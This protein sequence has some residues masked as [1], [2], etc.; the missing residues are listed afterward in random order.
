MLRFRGPCT[1]TDRVIACRESELLWPHLTPGSCPLTWKQ[2]RWKQRLRASMTMAAPLPRK[3]SHTQQVL[4]PPTILGQH[5]LTMSGQNMWED[6][7]NNML[8]R[9]RE[10]Q[11][12]QYAGRNCIPA[13]MRGVHGRIPLG[14]HCSGAVAGGG[15]SARSAVTRSDWVWTRVTEGWERGLAQIVQVVQR[16]KPAQV[17]KRWQKENTGRKM[18]HKQL[19]EAWA[20]HPPLHRNPDI[21]GLL[22]KAAAAL[23][24]PAVVSQKL[25]PLLHLLQNQL[26]FLFNLRQGLSFSFPLVTWI[27]QRFWAVSSV[28]HQNRGNTMMGR[29]RTCLL[30]V[31]GDHLVLG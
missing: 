23:T 28:H 21:D 14:Q 17:Q 2:A 27:D 1:D 7:E 25:S 26:P 4:Q 31:Y 20:I 8:Q 30:S 11:A 16:L 6:T 24:D 3:R 19:S 5:M 9:A 10:R 29:G 18:G 13:M 12:V 15:I 22:V